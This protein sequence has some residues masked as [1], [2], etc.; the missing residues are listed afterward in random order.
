EAVTLLWQYRP[1]TVEPLL[2][3]VLAESL[4]QL[5][6]ADH[7]DRLL[8]GDP[9]AQAA[10][11]RQVTRLKELE[12]AFSDYLREAPALLGSAL[13]GATDERRG[14]GLE[15][16]A[17][18]RADVARSVL[19]LLDELTE[20][21]RELAVQLMT[22]SRDPR[23]A[24]QLCAWATDRLRPAW[25]RLWSPRRPTPGSQAFAAVLRALRGHPSPATEAFLL[26]A[27]RGRDPLCRAAAVSSLGWWE[28][29]RRDDVLRC[30][31]QARRDGCA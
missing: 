19:P 3:R 1:D 15:A 22:W 8:R 16:L 7:T 4:R 20:P 6:R 26:H 10:G 24:P 29:V 27:A 17:D 25:R 21:Q 13:P 23:V 2:V 12:P 5:Q 18:L 30:L 28:P 31:H 9:A 14:E 11:R